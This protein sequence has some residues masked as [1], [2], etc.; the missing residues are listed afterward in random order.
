MIDRA[1]T[2][3]VTLGLALIVSCGGTDP[4][5]GDSNK[6][7]S[8]W[9]M[10]ANPAAMI[11]GPDSSF[12]I[13]ASVYNDLGNYVPDVPIEYSSD[14][15]GVAMVDDTGTVTGTGLGTATITISSKNLVETRTVIIVPSGTI[16]GHVPLGSPTSPPWSVAIHG[17]NVYVGTVGGGALY[18]GSIASRTV[19]ASALPT[20]EVADIVLSAAGDTAWIA[21]GPA[22]TIRTVSLPAGTT[23]DISNGLVAEGYFS[24]ARSR[25]TSGFF[26]GTDLNRLQSFTNTLDV[27][28]S[29]PKGL[30]VARVLVASTQQDLIYAGIGADVFRFTVDHDTLSTATSVLT[31]PGPGAVRDFALL[32][33]N[34]TLYVAT[35]LELF[36]IVT[37]SSGAKVDVPLFGVSEAIESSTLGDNV[38]ITSQGWSGRVFLFNTQTHQFTRVWHVGGTPRH[39]AIAGN[40]VIVVANNDGW[41]DFLQ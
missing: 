25:T 38:V 2:L 1:Q 5:N 9:Y 23:L 27:V 14:N 6:Y 41:V 12:H 39:A 20:G 28:A 40:G 36:T 21:N 11:L 26:A 35:E 19:S 31:V 10:I 15:S 29:V 17:D 3:T 37:V 33:D 8:G 4:S 30:G 7:P 32:P 34:T 24:L 16:L 22:G 13:G 18:T